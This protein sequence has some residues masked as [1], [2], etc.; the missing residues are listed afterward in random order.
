MKSPRKK[1]YA[2]SPFEFEA[3]A[4][5]QRHAIDQ[6]SRAIL[7]AIDI[8]DEVNV[9]RRA[10]RRCVNALAAARSDL[11]A[12]AGFIPKTVRDRAKRDAS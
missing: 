8:A 7:L 10:Q 1:P 4:N 11:R 5:L 6:V 3:M 12:L 2:V 9:D